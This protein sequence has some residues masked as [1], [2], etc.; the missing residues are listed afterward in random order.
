MCAPSVR[1]AASFLLPRNSIGKHLPKPITLS[2]VKPAMRSIYPVPLQETSRRTKKP[3]NLIEVK[4]LS[5]S[6][7][8]NHVLDGISF[9]VR[10]REMVTVVGPN[11]GGKTTLLLLMLGLLH[12]D[13]GTILIKGK[14]PDQV[15]KSIGYVPQYTHFDLDF[16]VNVFDVVLMGR[17][18][19]PFGFYSPADKKAA[20]LALENVGLSELAQRPFSDLSGG[21]RQ[22]VLIARALA[23]NPEMLFLD[24]P[25]ANVDPVIG[26]HLFEL[27]KKLNRQLT[28]IL[29]THD[30]GFVAK[31]TSRVFCIN[32]TFA[33][34]P[35]KAPG[36]EKMTQELYGTSVAAVQHEVH[37]GKCG[38]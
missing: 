37:L 35:V 32:R 29:V 28:I 17:L 30:M 22:R 15:Q 12:P 7:G 9:S 27:L 18:N 2:G 21:Q 6:Y 34:H 19:K 25:T 1:G 11:G 14:K 24:E 36:D 8:T 5:F 3:M 26:E 4:E 10:E 13:T 38:Q 33:E 31:F 23:G 20:R 16:P